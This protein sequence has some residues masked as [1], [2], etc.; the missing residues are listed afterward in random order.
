[1]S[2]EWVAALIAAGS[3]IATVVFG[4]VMYQ[5][6]RGATVAAQDSAAA[7]A[8]SATAAADTAR[9]E[10]D[11]RHDELDAALLVGPFIQET[12]KRADVDVFVMVRNASTRTYTVGGKRIHPGGGSS[13][14]HPV[15]LTPGT[16]EK[17]Y[18]GTNG[19]TP[20]ERLDLQISGDCPCGRGTRDGHWSR[21]VPVPPPDQWLPPDAN[22]WLRQ[23]LKSVSPG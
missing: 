22:A 4:L 19:R 3:L 1:M 23:L 5:V 7:A 10:L 21:S 8:S 2:A 12:N 6:T 9:V 17:L 13:S 16:T 18:I 20:P 11:R 14:I 15:D